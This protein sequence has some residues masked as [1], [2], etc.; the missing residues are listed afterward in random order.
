MTMETFLQEELS[1]ALAATWFILQVW[2][3]TPRSA[4]YSSPMACE[5]ACSLFWPPAFSPKKQ[6]MARV[7]YP[8]VTKAAANGSVSLERTLRMENQ[9]ED[10]RRWYGLPTRLL[11]S[12]AHPGECFAA[13]RP[14]A[15]PNRNNRPAECGRPHRPFCSRPWRPNI[16]LRDWQRYG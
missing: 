7:P 15:Y 13:H 4:K 2:P 9:A 16:C 5:M 11:H 1:R 3:S 14:A 10:L 12:C 6:K 8:T